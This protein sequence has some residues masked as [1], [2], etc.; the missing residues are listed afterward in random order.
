MI[1]LICPSQTDTDPTFVQILRPS[2]RI[3]SRDL[4]LALTTPLLV[5]ANR[6]VPRNP[7]NLSHKIPR[8]LSQGLQCNF[9]L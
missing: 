7:I 5:P 3:T 9:G 2:H 1:S 8:L 6:G 4:R